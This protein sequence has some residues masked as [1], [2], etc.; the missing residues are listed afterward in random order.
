MT[1]N[2]ALF[3]FYLNGPVLKIFTIS[4]T[5]QRK[6]KKCVI[7]RQN[8]N[9][10]NFYSLGPVKENSKSASFSVKIRIFP[11]FLSILDL[12]H[13]IQKVRHF[14]S[15][16]EFFQ[17]LLSILELSKK[18][19][20]VRHFP[21]KSEFFQFLLSILHLSKKIQKVRHFPSKL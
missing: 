14:P 1:E 3:E 11:I 16:A 8:Q 10:S 4:W 20:K 19:Q 6:F 15:R 2:D 13:K 18:I 12:S 17:F 9:F 21:S 5:C 7:F